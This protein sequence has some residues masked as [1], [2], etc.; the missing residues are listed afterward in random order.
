MEFSLSIVFSKKS[1]KTFLAQF[2]S[3]DEKKLT[4][5]LCPLNGQTVKAAA[6][7]RATALP[8]CFSK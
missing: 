3:L 2:L 4:K 8:S 6:R 5:Y 1:K 7:F